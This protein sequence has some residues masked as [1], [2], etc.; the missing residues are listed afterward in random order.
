MEQPCGIGVNLI[1][2]MG[3]LR[4]S[5]VN[6]LAQSHK[7]VDVILKESKAIAHFTGH[8]VSVFFI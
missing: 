3:N 2:Q 7:Q 1:F 5:K 8:A 4:L 6:Y